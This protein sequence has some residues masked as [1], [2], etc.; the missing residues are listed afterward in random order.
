M[1]A[2]NSGIG[3]K[4]IRRDDVTNED[5]VVTFQ[6]DGLESVGATIDKEGYY[7]SGSGYKFTSKSLLNRW[8]PWN[9]TVEVV[10]KKKRNPVPVYDNYRTSYQIPK[11]DT[12][13][14]FDLERRDWVAPFGHGLVSDFV[15]LYKSEIRAY[16]DYD[17]GFTLTF[18][19]PHDGIQEYFFDK[20]DQSYFKWPFEAPVEGYLPEI[21]KEKTMLLPGTGYNSDEKK[22]INYMFRVRS[23][24]DNEGNIVE[25]QYGKLIGEFGFVPKG[26]ITFRYMFNPDG[27]RNLEEDPE[28]NLFQQ[29]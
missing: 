5:G 16:T 11:F 27:T 6:G 21:S 28:K 4:T 3:L 17:C 8:E 2:N 13:I 18:S 24:V 9:P 19:N 7:Q 26:E 25:A 23:K 14:G 10:L 12:P 1:Q 20:E 29:K 15:I 22:T